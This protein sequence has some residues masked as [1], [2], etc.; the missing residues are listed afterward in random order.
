MDLARQEIPI[1][2]IADEERRRGPIG[3][4]TGNRPAQGDE[5]GD[6]GYRGGGKE[7]GRLGCS[8]DVRT[9]RSAVRTRTDEKEARAVW[10]TGGLDRNRKL[11][12]NDRDPLIDGPLIVQRRSVPQTGDRPVGRLSRVGR[13]RRR[14][15]LP[16]LRRRG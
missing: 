11:F 7:E 9:C 3:R 6:H 12:T 16:L 4:Q 13:R 15:G 1:S 2:R 5:M 8:A 14:L 10:R